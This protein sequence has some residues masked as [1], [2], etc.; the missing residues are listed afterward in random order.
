LTDIG[1]STRW[2]RASFSTLKIELAH[3]ADWSTHA[4]ARTYV[5][6]YLK[7]FYN[8]QRRH[9]VLGYVGPVIMSPFPR[10]SCLPAHL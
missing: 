9:S 1:A 5:A 6:E 2:P 3:D 7:I 8:A 4:D 10:L